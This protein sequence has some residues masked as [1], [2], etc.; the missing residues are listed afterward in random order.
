LRELY[1][2]K[3]WHEEAIPLSTVWK[4][5]SDAARTVFTYAPRHSAVDTA[6]K[7]IDRFLKAVEGVPYE[8]V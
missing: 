8:Q 6:W 3:L 5:A 4:E 7:L 2:G 1:P